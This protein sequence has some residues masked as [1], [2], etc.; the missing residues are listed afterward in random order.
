MIGAT[1]LLPQ[2]P[3]CS[4]WSKGGFSVLLTST[5]MFLL[6]KAMIWILQKILAFP[7]MTWA[8]RVRHCQPPH[9]LLSLPFLCQQ[10]SLCEVRTRHLNT[11]FKHI[12][13]QQSAWLQRDLDPNCANQRA[14]CIT[15]ETDFKKSKF[16]DNLVP[17][18][19]K[20]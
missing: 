17:F 7:D 13:V 16:K 4:C 12:Q 20:Y 2:T 9:T 19:H 8:I 18:H 14:V 1:L 3:V 6:H 5:L 11:A 15:T 10:L